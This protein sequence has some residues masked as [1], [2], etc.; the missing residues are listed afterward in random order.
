MELHATSRVYTWQQVLMIL[1]LVK[2]LLMWPKRKTL[3]RPLDKPGVPDHQ[4]SRY[5]SANRTSLSEYNLISENIKAVKLKPFKLSLLLG[6][7]QYHMP[8]LM[9]P[10][11]LDYFPNSLVKAETCIWDTDSEI[12]LFQINR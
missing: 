1:P 10:D 3:E 6:Y 12:F 5:S 11:K 2:K 4:T 8:W 7:V 9:K